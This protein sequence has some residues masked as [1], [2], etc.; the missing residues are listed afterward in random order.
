MPEGNEHAAILIATSY[1]ALN[2]AIQENPDTLITDC[3]VLILFAGFYVEATLNHIFKFL[4]KDI[5]A[6]PYSEK[7]NRGKKYPGLKDKLA[8]FYNE[9][10]EENK[11]SNW[12]ELKKRR[13]YSKTEGMFP[14]FSEIHKFRNDISHG[15][16]NHS[17][18]SLEIAKRLRQQAK[19]L[20]GQLYSITSSKGYNVPRLV[21]Y[22]D[23]I[24]SIANTSNVPAHTSDISV[25]SFYSS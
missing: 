18:K 25:S 1:Q 3:T 13:I 8:W 21:T 9:F 14:G 5:E 16:I 19:D 20:V 23:A 11:A 10:I 6:F 4:D 22:K 15:E 17:A 2:R 7:S 24:T 12:S